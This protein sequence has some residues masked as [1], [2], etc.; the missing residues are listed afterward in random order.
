M[1]CFITDSGY[2]LSS[3]VSL[4]YDLKIIPLRVY[5]GEQEYEDKQNISAEKLYE[6][7]LK[8]LVATTSLPK[9]EVI[10]RTIR[11][12]AKNYEEVYIITISSKL[13]NTH[14]LIKN[15][16]SSMNVKNVTVLDS[17]TACVKQGY[18]ILRAME[19]VKN[20]NKLRQEDIDRFVKESFLVFFVPTLEHLY[21]GGRIGKAKALIGKMLS[22]KP[23]LTT[24][25]EGEVSS[26]ATTRSI[27]SGVNTMQSLVNKFLETNN[28]EYDF[29]IIAAYTIETMKNH[30]EKLVQPYAKNVLDVTNIG[31]AISAHVGPEA[32]GLVVG[33]GVHFW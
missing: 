22:L 1:R 33:K 9:P 14:D 17:K 26:V 18:V 20:G 10:E 8:G 29:T 7:Q 4:P 12:S 13:S 28:F 24:D 5:I 2:D 27:D 11:E 25:D 15:I 16:V 3:K 31:P 21:R 23:I 30:L 19:H 32:F 6:N